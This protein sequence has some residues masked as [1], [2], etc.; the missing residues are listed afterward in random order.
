M[1]LH[2][3]PGDGH[4]RRLQRC[5]EESPDIVLNVVDSSNLERNLFLTT[6]LID[7]NVRIVMALNMYD[8]FQKSGSRL[9]Y[10]YLGSMLGFNIVPT[11]AF[12][13]VGINEVLD[14]IINTTNHYF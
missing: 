12:K 14:S 3:R 1:V 7:M 13:G 6:Q 11:V 2:E 8:E 10:E 5:C 4:F 9:D